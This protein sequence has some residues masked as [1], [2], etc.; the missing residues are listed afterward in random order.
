MGFTKRLYDYDAVIV[1]AGVGG[2]S[3]ALALAKFHGLRVLLVERHRGPGNLNRG[4]SL[5]PPV[6]ALLDKWDV[7]H[8]CCAAGARPVGH[9]Q[10]H[11]HC[12]GLVLDLPLS[13]P[14]VTDPYLVLPHPKIERVLVEATLATG[15]VEVCYSTHF[16]R[17][18]L[19]G[20]RACGV[21]LRQEGSEREVS[22]RVVIGA[23]GSHSRVRKALGIEMSI[24]RYNH[25]LFIVDIDR[26]PGEPD[27]L[28]TEL[29]PDGGILVVPGEDRLGLAALVHGKHENLLRS[30][31]VEKKFS[32]IEHRSPLL[33]GRTPSPVGA[34]LYKLWRGHAP[35]YFAKGVI[36]LGDA[37]HVINP[38]MAQGMTMA[39]E[40]AAALA[41]VLGPVLAEGGGN[42]RIDG[43]F[44]AYESVRRPFN[45]AVIRRSHWMSRL[46]ALGG[47]F[48][49]CVHSAVRMVCASAGGQIVQQ[50]IWASF[51]T[52]PEAGDRKRKG[53]V[54]MVNAAAVPPHP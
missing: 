11:H 43:C 22:T 33:F 15:S 12:H 21:V 27:V 36:L 10:F 34:H 31:S 2:A 39:I 9:M 40:D 24:E 42:A 50:R 1:G 44:A 18:L 28:R 32:H 4:E 16:I 51:A 8:R 35:N 46:F 17:L 6:T 45:A 29:H 14:G 7:L 5:L 3:C 54:S 37:V 53:E 25:S 13:L 38:V 47:P 30:G 19:E 52:S 41:R 20:E 49:E 48:G 26:P 23:D